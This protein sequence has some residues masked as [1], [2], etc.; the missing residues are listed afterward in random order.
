[1]VGVLVRGRRGGSKL[2]RLD[3]IHPNVLN[4]SIDLFPQKLGRDM[5][6]I[7]NPLRVLGRERR[8]GRHGIAAMGGDDLLVCL[9]TAVRDTVCK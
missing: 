1:M 5:V 3:N 9:E 8:C 6:N 7:V 4:N 2:T